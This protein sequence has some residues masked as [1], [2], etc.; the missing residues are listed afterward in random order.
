MFG[1]W[2]AESV[3]TLK[4]AAS[5]APAALDM[6]YGDFSN[7]WRRRLAVCLQKGNADDTQ[8]SR[9]YGVQISITVPI[10]LAFVLV[11]FVF[12]PVLSVC[13]D[14][15]S[16][17]SCPILDCPVKRYRNGKRQRV[18]DHIRRN[19]D[20]SVIPRDFLIRHSLEPCT[21]CQKP[22]VTR[23]H[24]NGFNALRRQM[25]KLSSR[26][27]PDVCLDYNRF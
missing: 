5:L 20:L 16:S 18:F 1:C 27:R 15:S 10:L 11:H 23:S 12:V 24:F 3:K 17:I 6:S 13:M 25:K 21:Y 7:Y 19:H 14:D 9:M 22:Y 2:G 8:E 26:P 4:E